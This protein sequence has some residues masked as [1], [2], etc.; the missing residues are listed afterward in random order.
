MI[1]TFNGDCQ[2]KRKI[3]IIVLIWSN[4]NNEI[5]MQENVHDKIYVCFMRNCCFKFPLN[6]KK[7]SIL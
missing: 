3:V 6:N 5:E 1:F 4:N 2:A 7:F